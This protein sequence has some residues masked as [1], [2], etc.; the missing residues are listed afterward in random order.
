MVFA[1]FFYQ[2]LKEASLTCRFLSTSLRMSLLAPRS[3]IVQ[4]LGSWHPSM[5]VKY[6]SAILRTYKKCIN[7]FK[8]KQDRFK[9]CLKTCGTNCWGFI[10][11][12]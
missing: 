9:T 1:G 3:K 6:S 7:L 4:A 10:E 12:F 8:M 2:I 11:R 5:K